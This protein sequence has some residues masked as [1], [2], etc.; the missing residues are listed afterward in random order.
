MAAPVPCPAYGDA[1]D[2]FH[3]AEVDRLAREHRDEVAAI[4]PF[5]RLVYTMPPYVACDDDVTRVSRRSSRS[6]SWSLP[7]L[8]VVSRRSPRKML[9]APA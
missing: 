2:L 8:G 4:I 5:G 9:L 3:V 7:G 6:W 1:F